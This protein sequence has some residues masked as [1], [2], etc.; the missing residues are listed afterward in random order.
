MRKYDTTVIQK[1][2][3]KRFSGKKNQLY[4]QAA[5]KAGSCSATV[6]KN[7]SGVYAPSPEMVNVLSSMLGLSV[8]EINAC[9]EE[10]KPQKASSGT[11]KKSVKSLPAT[12]KVLNIEAIEE[13][14]KKSGMS[15]PR[16]CNILG[17]AECSFN[18]W[19]RNRKASV[20]TITRL[21]SLLNVDPE[22]FWEE[23]TVNH[24]V[25][26][27][28]KN[29]TAVTTDKAVTPVVA[30][31]EIGDTQ[32]IHEIFQIINSNILALGRAFEGHISSQTVKD[33][34]ILTAINEL[35]HSQTIVYSMDVKDITDKAEPAKEEVKESAEIKP[36]KQKPV[37]ISANE[38]ETLLKSYNQSDDYEEYNRKI[39][40]MVHFISVYGK[41]PHK[42]ILHRFYKEMNKVYGVVYEQLK[43][44]FIAKYHH[45]DSGSMELIYED[46]I[47]REIFFNIISDELAKYANKETQTA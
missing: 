8:E 13:A 33:E 44:D 36:I 20:E 26:E 17:I 14:V 41:E 27:S 21:A 18:N 4:A 29:I 23:P 2:V 19:K 16:I 34:E 47:F 3:N 46:A 38:I 39:N 7:I 11:V 6:Q 30:L 37:A 1:A 42:E 12:D 40:R 25:E 9:Y 22:T 15:K 31:K 35:K 45:R 24:T 28:Q 5:K 32:N 10:K 43:K